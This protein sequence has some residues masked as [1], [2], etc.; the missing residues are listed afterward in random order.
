MEQYQL[1]EWK[2]LF[3][4]I[5]KDEEMSN[6]NQTLRLRIAATKAWKKQLE[7]DQKAMIS[8]K[9]KDQLQP[10]IDILGFWVDIGEQVQKFLPKSK[11]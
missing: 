6:F 7:K 8:K 11:N 4:F 1:H 5:G 9:K 10:F 2:N 3:F